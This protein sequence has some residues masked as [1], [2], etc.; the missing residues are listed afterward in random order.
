MASILID[1]NCSVKPSGSGPLSNDPRHNLFSRPP[2]E[3]SFRRLDDGT[4]QLQSDLHAF[5]FARRRQSIRF[6]N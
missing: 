3:N 1:L 2:S 6:S 5:F 4:D